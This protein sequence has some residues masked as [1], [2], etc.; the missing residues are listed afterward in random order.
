MC[1]QNPDHQLFCQTLQDEIAFGPRN[2]GLSADEIRRRVD[3]V[4]ELVGLRGLEK[5]HPSFLGRG[6]RRRVAVGSIVA[7]KPAVIVV[8]EPKTGQ[9][10]KQS[11]EMMALL[12]SLNSQGCTIVIITNNMR[13]VAEHTRR[14]IVM[15]QGRIILDDTT[16]NVF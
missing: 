12:D 16:R 13:I 2:L 7:M 14:T 4:I 11:K 1:F 15:H 3:E 10:W 5:E 9:D 6:Q 8:D